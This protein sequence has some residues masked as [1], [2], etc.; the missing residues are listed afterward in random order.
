MKI[1]QI[2]NS[3]NSAG[4]SCLRLHNLFLEKGVDSTIVSLHPNRIL[5]ESIIYLTN[6]SRT[7]L[8]INTKLEEY[9]NRKNIG[10]FGT[11]S[12]PI[13]GTDISKIDA[14]LNADIVYLHWIL[15]GFLNFSNLEQ[16]FKLKKPVIIF[17]HDMWWITGGCHQSF[18]CEKYKLH[19]YNCQIFPEDKKKDLSYQEF[20]K[21]LKLYSKYRNVFFVSPSRWLYNCAKVSFLTA[22][23][24]IHYIPNILDDRVF[25]PMAKTF[26]RKV[27][28]LP[29]N[30]KILC[31]G[32]ESVLSPY[33]GWTYLR[34]ALQILYKEDLK[35]ISIL[36]FG[37]SSNDEI[38]ASIPF[39]THF[40]GYLND[41]YSL[42]LIY[43]SADVF[44]APS[45]A[46]TFGYVILE[47]LSCGTPVVGFNVGGI[48]DL[49]KH[50]ENGYLA[51]YK[52]SEDLAKGIK[53]CIENRIEGKRLPI[54]E[55]NKVVNEHLELI[56][57]VLGWKEKNGEPKL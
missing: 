9:R 36:I 52:D 24:P 2:Q 47:A 4:S 40:I 28:N 39:T 43:N 46:E 29:E 35:D 22:N 26:A 27:L 41:E 34:D 7:L 5:D 12:Y 13:L 6:K 18:G 1:V 31:F 44:I 42:S 49:I 33:K 21:K 48:P 38:K 16:L 54:F 53:Y 23:K 15:G 51:N 45:L 50:K 3:M 55:K 8:R 57:L 37:G 14:I 30:N 25:K 19:C 32:A 17:M 10:E 20:E 11:F 56:N